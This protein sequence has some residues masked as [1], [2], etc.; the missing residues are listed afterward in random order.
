[1]EDV[2]I[3]Y[4]TAVLLKEKRF[5]LPV[6]DFFVV[7]KQSL[8]DDGGIIGKEN[9]NEFP[10]VISAPTQSLCCKW[11]REEHGIH[12]RIDCNNGDWYYTIQS[13]DHGF[14]YKTQCEESYNSYEKALEE[15]LYISVQMI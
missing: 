2:I 6:D 9:H 3:E 4:K 15:G 8:Y 1:M 11:L 12:I 10:D 5:N 14:D 7:S 13:I